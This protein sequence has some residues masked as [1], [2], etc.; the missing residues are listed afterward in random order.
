MRPR[1]GTARVAF[2]AILIAGVLALNAS[3]FDQT[4][5]LCVLEFAALALLAELALSSVARRRSTMGPTTTTSGL[6]CD[7]KPLDDVTTT[8]PPGT[9]LRKH[10]AAHLEAV[11]AALEAAGCSCDS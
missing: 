3:A 11:C 9:P 10:L 7:G 8:S 6:E 5:V 4:E 2:H 1:D